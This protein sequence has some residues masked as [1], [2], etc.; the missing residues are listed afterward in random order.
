MKRALSLLAL[1]TFLGATSTAA[2]TLPAGFQETPVA[3]GLP[4]PTSM[5]LAPDGRIFVT[6]QGGSLRVIKDGSLLP[7]P[8]L[9]VSV[10]AVGERGLLG[11][12]FDPDFATNQYVYVYY[13]ATTPTIHNRVS[14]FTA[15]GDVAAEGETILLDLDDLSAS[16]HN[17][18]A[19]HFGPDGKLYAATGEN[20]VSSN[21]Q[22]LANLLGK[23]LRLNGDGSIPTDNPFHATATGKNRAIW[24]L[25]LRNPFT[26]AFRRTTGAMFINDVGASTWEEINAGAAGANYGWPTTEGPTSDPRFVSPLYAYR[27][28]D[29]CAIS[30]GDFYDPAIRSFPEEYLG[31]Y[32]FADYCSG[33]I[34]RIDSAS[35]TL[36]GEFASGI[37]SPVDI[38]VATDGT[39]YYLGRG[40]GSV[41]H[42]TLVDR[43]GDVN[44]NGVTGSDDVFYLVN[45]LFAGGTAPVNSADANGDGSV[46]AADVFYLVNYLF[47]SGPA[48]KN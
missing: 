15:N 37:S 32:F 42:V 22:T 9:T 31:D 26:F 27:H 45:F 43:P 2:A 29:G 24:A 46:D 30:G 18:G 47:A 23:I 8:F 44:G 20:A 38:D 41:M 16:N 10:S 28:T 19:I 36:I 11:V 14:R 33:W 34:R 13:T 1:A 21:A 6:L 3:T 25:G 17:G 35:G 12:T 39:L 48:P 40:T 7:Q 5:T 4:N